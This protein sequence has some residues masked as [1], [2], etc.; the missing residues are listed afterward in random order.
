[1]SDDKK[2]KKKKKFQT[3]PEWLFVESVYH[4]QLQSLRILKKNQNIKKK[5]SNLTTC[6]LKLDILPIWN[7]IEI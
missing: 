7:L 4:V 5:N 1:M 3:T 6:G 2:K